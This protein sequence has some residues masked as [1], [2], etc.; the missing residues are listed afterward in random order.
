MTGFGTPRNTSTK[1]VPENL[2]ELPEEVVRMSDSE[3][4]LQSGTNRFASQRGM[5]GFGTG[6]D[7]VSEALAPPPQDIISHFRL[8]RKSLTG[9]GVLDGGQ[10]ISCG[11][12]MELFHY[13][14]GLT[15]LQAREA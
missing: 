2:Q 11:R 8:C 10:W 9:R 12:R 15:S 4:R 13:S 6:R 1:V 5:I 7:V 14:M 3:V